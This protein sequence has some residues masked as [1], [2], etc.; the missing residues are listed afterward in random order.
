M[1]TDHWTALPDS[2]REQWGYAPRRTIGPLAFGMDRDRA[3][4]V[5]AG[6]GFA[7]EHHH[8]GAWHATDRVQRR[9]AFRRPGPW[10]SRPALKCYFVEGAGL[11]CVLVDGLLGPQVTHGG[12]R[13]IGRVPSELAREMEAYAV[14]HDTGL[15]YSPGG[16]LSVDGFEIEL[17]AQRAG[18]AVVTWALFFHTGDIAG[19]SWDI[20]PSEVWRHW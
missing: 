13:L 6:H 4:T 19:T 9:V 20:A 12:I 11:T 10:W 2:E 17:G 3:V 8:M 18:D 5:M 15:R 7:A 16:D 14:E 1:N